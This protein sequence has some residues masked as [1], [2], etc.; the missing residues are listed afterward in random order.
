MLAFSFVLYTSSNVSTFHFIISRTIWLT[1]VFVY[2]FLEC[3]YSFSPQ[4]TYNLTQL[5]PSSND[6][7]YGTSVSSYYV[8]NLCSSPMNTRCAKVTYCLN[9]SVQTCDAIYLQ[10]QFDSNWDLACDHSFLFTV[11]FARSRM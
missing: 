2:D 8:V 7:I 3:I 1:Y 6:L 5:S 10:L 11:C 4:Y 9:L